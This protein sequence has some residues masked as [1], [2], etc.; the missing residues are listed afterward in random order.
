[1][2]AAF[3]AEIRWT[4]SRGIIVTLNGL[5]SFDDAGRTQ[6]ETNI[7]ELLMS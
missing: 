7:P 6:T 1:M 5:A 4:A 3:A 2:T